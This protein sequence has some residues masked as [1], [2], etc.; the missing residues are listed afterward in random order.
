MFKVLLIIISICID[1]KKLIEFSL[2]RMEASIGI[3]NDLDVC[4][5]I[6]DTN[7]SELKDN[8]FTSFSVYRQYNQ[9]Y[10]LLSNSFYS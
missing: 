10:Q 3:V 1:V 9:K 2:L 5:M 8:R 4:A 7:S 6:S